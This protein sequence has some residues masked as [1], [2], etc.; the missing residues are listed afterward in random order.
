VHVSV[1]KSNYVSEM[2]AAGAAI[3]AF[4]VV[5]LAGLSYL[6]LLPTLLIGWLPAAALA[7][8]TARAVRN[9]M[10]LFIELERNAGFDAAMAGAPPATVEMPRSGRLHRH[11]RRGRD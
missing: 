3:G 5:Y 2:T 10:S 1:D 8:V 7:M 9:L 6:G 4:L 11:L